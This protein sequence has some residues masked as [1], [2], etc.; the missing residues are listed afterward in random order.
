V[1]QLPYVQSS[2]FLSRKHTFISWHVVPPLG[3]DYEMRNYTTAVARQWP[4]SDHVGTPTGTNAKIALQQRKSDFCA[5]RAEMLQA[6]QVSSEL[7][8]R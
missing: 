5:V 8:K 4:S 3:S 6:R 7:D 2:Q 1:K